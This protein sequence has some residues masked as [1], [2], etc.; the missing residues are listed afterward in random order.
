MFI[1]TCRQLKFNV[2]NIQTIFNE[3]KTTIIPIK[4][5]NHFEN[6]KKKLF[7]LALG[8]RKKNKWAQCEFLVDMI[9][10]IINVIML[11]LIIIGMLDTNYI[12]NWHS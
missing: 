5:V 4:L 9:F 11:Q 2:L 7:Q 1:L 8:T 10:C 6:N 3:T 12:I